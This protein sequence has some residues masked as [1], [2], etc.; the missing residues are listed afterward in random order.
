M[1]V[2]VVVTV[3]WWWWW[4]SDYGNDDDLDGY[5]GSTTIAADSGGHGGS[6]GCVHNGSV[7]ATRVDSIVGSGERVMKVVEVRVMVRV[8]I[9]DSEVKNQEGGITWVGLK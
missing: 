2:V 7:G 6:G 1:T 8:V 3:W 4:W 9:W 5:T